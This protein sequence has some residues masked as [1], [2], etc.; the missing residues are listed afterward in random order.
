MTDERYASFFG[1]MV[2]AGVVRS[3]IDFRKAYTLRFINH[4]VGLDLRPKN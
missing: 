1:K 4:G 3:D 2:R